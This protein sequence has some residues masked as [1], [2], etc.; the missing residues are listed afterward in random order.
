MPSFDD[1]SALYW[2][3]GASPAAS[4]SPTNIVPYE[5]RCWKDDTNKYHL[6]ADGSPCV[7]GL[8]QDCCT[9]LKL[10]APIIDD[11]RFWSK[12][13]FTGGCWEWFGATNDRGYGQ[14]QSGPPMNKVLYAHRLS[15]TMFNCS[16]PEGWNVDHLCR[17]TSCV[18][19]EHL[20]CVT[21]RE[22]VLR[23]VGPTAERARQTHCVRGHELSGENLYVRRE[24]WRQC[25]ACKRMRDQNLLS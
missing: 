8:C 22:N 14:I 20:E 1:L 7:V 3:W 10:S 6:R 17:N 12:V 16:I 11:V 9:D 4:S 24:G 15:Y 18:R 5:E 2:G 13:K 21:F 19:P 23:G 25:K